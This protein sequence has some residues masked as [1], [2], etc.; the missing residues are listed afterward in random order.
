MNGRPSFENFD[1]LLRSNKGIERRLIFDL[2]HRA[3]A[4]IDLGSHEYLGLGSVSFGDFRLAHRILGVGRMLSIERSEYAARADFNRPY[5]CIDVIA[6]EGDEVLANLEESRWKEPKIVWLDYDGLL[7][8]D[9][10]GDVQRFVTS[11]A[12]NSVLI[13]TV[14]ATRVRYKKANL[15]K[16][17]KKRR[18][19]TSVG[20]IEA[21]VGKNVVGP[22]FEPTLT[23]GGNAIDLPDSAFPELIASSLLNFIRHKVTKSGRRVGQDLLGFIPLFNFS[24]QDGACMVTVGGAVAAGPDIDRWRSSI[25][26]GSVELDSEGNPKLQELDLVPLT[27][28][29]KLVLDGCLP[30][31]SD[32]FI[33]AAKGFGVAIGDEQLLKYRQYYRQLPVYVESSL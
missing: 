10:C 33:S 8:R 17:Q 29:E 23:E 28:K 30:L 26:D 24:H 3:S 27:I 14:N 22:Q 21:I 1:Y 6:S 32:E 7:S 11:A 25:P 16:T 15:E 18:E 31:P 9:A 13:V 20:V 2:L 5:R 12:S 4:L 19:D